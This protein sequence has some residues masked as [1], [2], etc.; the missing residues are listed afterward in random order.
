M[1]IVAAIEVDV[2]ASI[3]LLTEESA[4]KTRNTSPGSEI[5][6]MNHYSLCQ[7]SILAAVTTRPW[8]RSV[9]GVASREW[10]QQGAGLCDA[11]V[12]T[13]SLDH[14]EKCKRMKGG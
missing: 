11:V 6:I 14:C 5:S 13:H 8:T 1:S 12:L 3:S 4:K 9:T 7:E 2:K 10:T